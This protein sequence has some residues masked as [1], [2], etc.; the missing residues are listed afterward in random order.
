[1][2]FYRRNFATL[3]YSESRILKCPKNIVGPLYFN[4]KHLII[5]EHWVEL[6][7]S[8]LKA[9]SKKAVKTLNVLNATGNY[10]FK[11]AFLIHSHFSSERVFII[12][13]SVISLF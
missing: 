10:Q 7:I 11:S 4:K 5:G 8:F 1:M 3:W 9:S 6:K 13:K 2:L 12:I